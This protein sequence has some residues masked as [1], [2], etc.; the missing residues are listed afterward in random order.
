[1]KPRDPDYILIAATFILIAAGLVILFS[2]SSARGAFEHG[3]PAYFVKR[4]ILYGILPGLL[5]MAVFWKMSHK[6][7]KKLSLPMF[8]ASLVSMAALFIEPFGVTFQGATRWLDIG[9]I[10]FQP[11]EFFKF[12]LAVYLAAFFAKRQREISSFRE[13]TLPFLVFLSVAGIL[14]L[15][16]PA[17]GTFGVVTLMALVMYFFS[18][19]RITN[20]FIVASIILLALGG[21]II[22]AD[23]HR[24]DR[25]MTFLNPEAD[26]RGSAYQIHQA[27]IAIGSGG[28]EGLG[29]GQSRQKY[30]FLP[31]TIGDSIFAIFAEETGFIGAMTLLA[32]FILILYRSFKI[33][34]RANDVFARLL[35]IGLATWIVGQAFINIAAITGLLPLTGITLPFISYGGSALTASL[36]A[37]GVLFNLSRHIKQ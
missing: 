16:Q 24:M 12:A 33:A 8:A 7:L 3:D 21:I 5:A 13:A 18:G 22:I 2:A 29:L 19:A 31:E 34:L 4:Q 35:A 27:L 6:W 26:P 30:Y 23:D 14:L 1:M 10:T 15:S 32:F 36:A 20:L 11:S 9:P 37:M 17:T 25:I 28:L